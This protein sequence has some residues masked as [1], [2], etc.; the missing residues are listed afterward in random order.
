MFPGE[1]RALVDPLRERSAWGAPGAPSVDGPLWGPVGPVGSAAP[2]APVAALLVAFDLHP[3]QARVLDGFEFRVD[4]MRVETSRPE[5]YADLDRRERFR[6]VSADDQVRLGVTGF[7][8]PGALRDGA[9]PPATVPLLTGQGRD[10]GAVGGELRAAYRRGQVDDLIADWIVGF[11]GERPAVLER[12]LRR[13][14]GG[15]RRG[16]GRPRR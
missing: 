8:R 6:P 1:A 5:A 16:R 4:W 11:L 13:V 3:V 14:A 2:V 10:V 7:L 9:P 15:G 12:V